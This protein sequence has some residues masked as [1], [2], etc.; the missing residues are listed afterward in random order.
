MSDDPLSAALQVIDALDAL[1]IAYYVGGSMASSTYGEYRASLDADLVADLR[2]EHVDRFVKE[3][4][5]DFYADG[6]MIHSAIK[7]KSSI[8]L[9][10]LPLASKVDIFIPGS[11]PFDDIRFQRRILQTISQ[12]PPRSVYIA[13]PE[14]TILAKLEWYRLGNEVSERQWRDV[15]GVLRVQSEHL[16]LDYLGQWAAKLAIADL[17]ERALSEVEMG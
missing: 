1:E 14:D 17:L 11:R 13:S 3:L 10:Y 4:G 5:K 7:H 2:S 16:D 9:I 12:D 6:E 15:L 8:N